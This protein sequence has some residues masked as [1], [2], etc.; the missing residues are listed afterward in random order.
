MPNSARDPHRPA[1]FSHTLQYGGLAALSGLLCALPASAALGLGRG[2]GD[3]ARGALRLRRAVAEEN[4]AAAFPELDAGA[5]RRIVAGMYRHYGEELAQF[6]RFPVLEPA[7]I[8]RRMAVEGEHHLKEAVAAGRGVLILSGHI[9][10]WEIMAARL[11]AVGYPLTLL[12]GPQRNRRVQEMFTRFRARHGVQVLVRGTDLRQIFKALKAGRVVATLGDQD[13]GRN[14][15]FVDFLGRPASTAL[16]P[17]RIAGRAG[18]PLVMGFCVRSGADWLGFA[19]PPLWPD[20]A[21]DEEIQARAWSA[22][23]HARLAAFIRAYPE[24]WFWV[25]RRWKS[26]PAPASHPD[27]DPEKADPGSGFPEARP[28]PPPAAPRPR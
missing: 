23:Y 12:V 11:A 19:E 22:H 17:Y 16:G 8:V 26:R 2:L 27:R 1:P 24:Q 6:A 14:G 25:H 10:S 20:P 7:D 13:A 18:A 9:G 5:R 3:F 4:V 21:Q 15:W 28:D